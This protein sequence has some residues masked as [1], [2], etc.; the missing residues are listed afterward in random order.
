MTIECNVPGD[1]FP[2]RNRKDA[3]GKRKLDP[4]GDHEAD[5]GRAQRT[6]MKSFFITLIFVSLTI[7]RLSMGIHSSS[8]IATET[9]ERIALAPKTMQANAQK[10][11]ALTPETTQANAKNRPVSKETQSSHI[12]PIKDEKSTKNEMGYVISVFGNSSYLCGAIIL[13]WALRD[14]DPRYD[15]VAVISGQLDS[16]ENYIFTKEVLQKVG[17]RV[18]DSPLL[19]KPNVATNHKYL[20]YHYSKLNVVRAIRS[21]NMDIRSWTMEP[22]RF[23]LTYTLRFMSL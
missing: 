18:Y 13:A 6:R 10:N 11:P 16:Y 19:M 7:G 9:K 14:R 8:S 2:L 12:R 5:T 21:I 15:L 17:Y 22:W 23:I 4:E 3:N 1:I 20:K